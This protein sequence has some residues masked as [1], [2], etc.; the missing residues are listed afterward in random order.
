MLPDRTR[1]S[2]V[3]AR[4]HHLIQVPKCHVGQRGSWG[5]P[6]RGAVQS[7][8]HSSRAGPRVP[9]QPS[10]LHPLHLGDV[11]QKW[12]HISVTSPKIVTIR[13]ESTNPRRNEASCVHVTHHWKIRK[14]APNAVVPIAQQVTAPRTSTPSHSWQ[15]RFK[16]SKGGGGGRGVIIL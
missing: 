5:T 12:G 6:A 8:P 4:G 16:L 15:E 9:F 2:W 11:Q 13:S 14:K 3:P 1:L 10:C 7:A